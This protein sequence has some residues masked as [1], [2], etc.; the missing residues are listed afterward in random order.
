MDVVRIEVVVLV[1]LSGVV[2]VLVGAGVVDV[3]RIEVVVLVVRS[4]VVLEVVGAGV[5]D[6]VLTGHWSFPCS[7][8][9]NSEQ[10]SPETVLPSSHCSMPCP[11]SM[12]VAVGHTG[13][14]TVDSVYFSSWSSSATECCTMTVGMV[15]CAPQEPR[16]IW[17]SVSSVFAIKMAMAPFS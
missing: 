5:V 9:Q 6:V 4:G 12:C 16:S 10:P 8:M 7:H 17:V 3:V 14:M 1:V 2:L 15:T 11:G 13:K